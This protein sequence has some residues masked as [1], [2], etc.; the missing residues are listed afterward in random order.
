[1]HGLKKSAVLLSLMALWPHQSA[2][3]TVEHFDRM[4]VGDQ[5]HYVMFLVRE[6]KKLLIDE[7]QRELARHLERLFREVPGG[8]DRSRGD[9]QFEA[10]MAA[11]RSSI[12][13]ISLRHAPSG[14]VEFAFVE[15]LFRLGIKP[16][17]AFFE[18]FGPATYNRAFFQKELSPQP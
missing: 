8:D 11:A 18:K 1:M 2:A 12:L 17:P 9:R 6:A 7:G 5:R 14:E 3:M 13:R 4:V 15:A 16:S 10:S